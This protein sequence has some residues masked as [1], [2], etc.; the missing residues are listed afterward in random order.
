MRGITVGADLACGVPADISITA[1]D[2]RIID[3]H[4]RRCPRSRR[5]RRHHLAAAV[6][7]GT[8]QI[9]LLLCDPMLG[10]GAARISLISLAV[11]DS[12][13]DAKANEIATRL[14]EG[15]QTAIRWTKPLTTGCDRRAQLSTRLCPWTSSGFTGPRRAKALP[16]RSKSVRL[17]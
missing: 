1:N 10:A 3:G 11:D 17:G 7:N 2:C 15:A 6:R 16:L 9:Y 4:T 5:S 13:V 12:E 8:G 14:A